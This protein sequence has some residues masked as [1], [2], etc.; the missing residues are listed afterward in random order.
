[1]GYYFVLEFLLLGVLT[2]VQPSTA[3][4]CTFTTYNKN[5]IKNAEKDCTEV[6]LN[7]ISVPAGV[8][9]EINL[10]KGAKL[11]FQ[12]TLTW[13][14]YEW[15]GPLM[16]ITGTNVEITGA[17][18]H[19]LNG[20][21]NL[22]WDGKG[23]AD[24]GKVKPVTL[25]LHGLKNSLVHNIH[26]KNPPYHAIWIE[27]SNGV[28]AEDVKVDSLDG[29]VLGRNTDGFNVWKSDN[30]TIRRIEIY[31]QDDCATVKSG[32]NVVITDSYCVYGHGLSIGSVG[33]RDYNIVE[34]VS[35]SNSKV[36]NSENGVRIKTNYGTT[37]SV[38]NVTFEN[39][40]LKDIDVYGIKIHGDYGSHVG[41]ATGGVP[42]KEFTLKNIT[43]T[44]KKTG[45]NVYILVKNATDWHWSDI[46]VTGG[47]AIVECDGIPEGSSIT[48]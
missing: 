39:I 45:S 37:G 26:I 13:E 20:R 24:K 36:V 43:G 19:I 11:T 10:K 3:A 18:D 7:G 46:N 14:Y 6:I 8:T 16:N 28:I 32:T 23:D 40:T 48:C 25:V 38:T 9:L 4:T 17:P 15:T 21:G 30:V 42:I 33:G 47:E 41:V 12:G 44:V 2:I 27:E 35:I 5:D 22:W 31:N 1:M 29:R 34:N